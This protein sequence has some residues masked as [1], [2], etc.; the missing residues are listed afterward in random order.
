MDPISQEMKERLEALDYSRKSPLTHILYRTP[1]GQP[2]KTALARE[3]PL[4]SRRQRREL[5]R[6][7]Q[8]LQQAIK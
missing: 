7:R 5:Q 2:L 1:N 4:L 3:F 8:K 6:A